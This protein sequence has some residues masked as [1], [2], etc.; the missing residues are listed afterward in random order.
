M[1]TITL[2]EWHCVENL[3]AADA[4]AYEPAGGGMCALGKMNYLVNGDPWH[5]VPV[6]ARYNIIPR[7]NNISKE[8]GRPMELGYFTYGKNHPQWNKH[9]QAFRLGL[10]YLI[11]DGIIKLE[12]DLAKEFGKLVIKQETTV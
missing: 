10:M 1:K 5:Q 3:P 4:T 2:A 6:T 9:V 12:D 8:G 11:E 7:M